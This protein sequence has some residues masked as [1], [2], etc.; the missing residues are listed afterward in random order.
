MIVNTVSAIFFGTFSDRLQDILSRQPQIVILRHAGCGVGRAGPKPMTPTAI[1]QVGSRPSV[2]ES[3]R[4]WTNIVAQR[5]DHT[6]LGQ[7]ASSANSIQMARWSL[8]PDGFLPRSPAAPARP[9]DPTQTI[10]ATRCR[11]HR[12]R[13]ETGDQ[14]S[15][16]GTPNQDKFGDRRRD[17]AIRCHPVRRNAGIGWNRCPP[18][19][20]GD[21]LRNSL[22]GPS[23]RDRISWRRRLEIARRI[24]RRQPKHR[25]AAGFRRDERPLPD[26]L[27]H[28]R[29]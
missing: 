29:R 20:R 1:L 14:S 26:A 10:R 4:A 24:D 3:D 13:K 12:I 22:C 6:R 15:A 7:R 18:V 17:G 2:T 9:S 28:H 5:A 21:H 27:G 25:G 16:R 19:E 8:V 11:I 23:G